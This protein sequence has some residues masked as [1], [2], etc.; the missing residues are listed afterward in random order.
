MWLTVAS[1]GMDMV[2]LQ[3]PGEQRG[4]GWVPRSGCACQCLAAA[5]LL[6]M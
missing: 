3:I 4:T 6:P 1:Q 5:R 2:P